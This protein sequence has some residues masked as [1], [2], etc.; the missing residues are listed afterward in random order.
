MPL[1]ILESI[2][3]AFAAVDREFRYS[4]MNSEA[5]RLSG[6]SHSELLGRVICEAFPETAGTPLE[7]K[8]R[9]ALL[10]QTPVEFETYIPAWDRWFFHKAYP[11]K[12][13]AGLVL[14]WKEITAGKRDEAYLRRQAQLLTQ[15]HDS[16]IAT[17][18]EGNITRWNH[19]AE[20]I[21]GYPPQEAIG[22]HISMLSFPEDREDV[23]QQVFEP[24]LRDGGLV[25]ELRNRRRSGQECFIRLSL[26]L[27]CGDNGAPLELLG[28]AIDITEQRQA[29]M[30]LR[31]SEAFH[32]GLIEA[33]PGIMFR[34]DSEGRTTRIGARW[35]E[36][37]GVSPE[38]ASASIG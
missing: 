25:L 1:S 32:R 29:E 35:E 3:D 37:S 34:T 14:I 27:V 2:T 20:C 30:A 8:C 15:V 19:A 5:E 7:A 4:W 31:E 11:K 16:I 22:H 23:R 18:L 33:M 28:V 24:L 6:K 21:F 17:D 36:Y 9:E 38:Q 12:E 10:T 13:G 26:S